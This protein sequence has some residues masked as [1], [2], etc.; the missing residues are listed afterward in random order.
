MNLKIIFKRFVLI[1]LAIVILLIISIFFQSEIVTTFNETIN[2]ENNMSDMLAILAIIY[3]IAWLVSL[4]LLYKFK[5]IGKQIYLFV[6]IFGSILS[7]LMGINAFGPIE[8]L[9]EG[10][11]WATS[12]AILALLY[13]SPIK[14]EF[15]K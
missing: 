10:L 12:G 7:L 15:D 1:D 5:P 2:P 8:Y 4:Y 9:I 14:K 13:F 11:S 6:F 3:L